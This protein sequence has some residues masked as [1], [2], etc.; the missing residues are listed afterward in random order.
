MP[1]TWLGTEYAHST[2]LT[3]RPD[4]DREKLA[5][6]GTSGG[7]LQTELIS[8]LDS[9]IKVSIPV[10]YGG[11]A[12]DTPARRGLGMI[13]IDALIA[14]RP[15]LMV[16][17]TG[18]PRAGVAGKQQRHELISH[19]Y[20]VAKAADR[21]RFAIFEEPH[22]YGPAIRRG[23]YRWLSQWLRGVEPSSAELAEETIVLEPESALACTTTGQ[24]RTA[25]GGET[26]S[27]LNRAEAARIRD[28]EPLP[29]NRDAWTD[30]RQRLRAEV[31]SRIALS[32]K[33]SPL[34][35]RKIET[36]ISAT[37]VLE[38]IVYD[39]EPEVYVPSLLLLP[40]VAQPAPAAIFV[41][42]GGKTAGG[43]VDT[44]LRPLVESG[45][46]VFA[47]DLRGTGETAPAANPESSY[48]GFTSDNESRLMYDALSLGMTP[49]GMRTR[50]VLRA[51]D[52]LSTRAEIDRNR[53]SVIGH[54]SAGLAALH[55]AALDDRLRSAAVTAALISYSEVVQ[56]EIYTHRYSTFVPGALRKYDLPELASLIAPRP[57]VV[58]NAV[59]ELQRPVELERAVEAYKPARSIFDLTGAGA[60]FRVE[61]AVAASEILEKYRTL[62]LPKD[63]PAR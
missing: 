42:D 12:P 63:R 32:R 28:R 46:A 37:Y 26:V 16:E 62:L 9:R 13:D 35:A 21:T 14:P 34:N 53:I 24:V 52:Y 8:A 61:Q 30:W 4:V 5:C 10:C 7:G 19:L 6:T 60:A 58:I 47:I 20:Q 31:E 36:V 18:D 55:A 45:I 22:G 38:K 29:A 54:G 44:Y 50:D 3:E 43:L 25:L 11:C 51:L 56:K 48:R 59:D 33:D 15:L 49:L 40:K 27:T 57:L 2:I 17:A 23:A 1:R 41:N 39:S